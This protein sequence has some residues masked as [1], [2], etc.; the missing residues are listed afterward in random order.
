LNSFGKF[1]FKPTIGAKV[2]LYKTDSVIAYTF[3]NFDLTANSMCRVMN[4]AGTA[5]SEA[6]AS[7]V[8]A[9]A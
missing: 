8:V 2:E 6:V 1:T 4:S 7:C 3:G 9:T 5:Y